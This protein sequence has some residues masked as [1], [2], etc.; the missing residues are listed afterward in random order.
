[1]CN[2]PPPAKQRSRFGIILTIFAVAWLSGCVVSSN[3]KQIDQLAS[4]GG[5]PRIV[6]MPPDIR[7]YLL[8]ASGISEAHAEW[9]SAAQENF[10]A[11]VLEYAESIGSD[12]S[13]IPRNDLSKN[14]QE[15][16]A[17][18]AAVGSTL[19]DHHFGVLTL[20]SKN[21]EFDWS[22]GPG[23]KPIGERRDADYAL[24]VYYRDYQASGGRMAFAVLAAVAGT[25]IAT[26]SESGFA[27]LVDLKTGE[28]VWFNVV[29]AGAGE[30]RNRDS[31][32]KTVAALFK[33]IPTAKSIDNAE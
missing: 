10:S 33:D 24:F 12:L 20:P 21:G 27:S 11:S 14:E 17:L 32:D 2:R 13:A 30:L 9:T 15:Y 7:Y 16:A 4:I 22:L 31:A 5:D 26:G 28:I 1:M 19:L 18:H 29:N 8:T 3:V 6:L 25:A 23:I